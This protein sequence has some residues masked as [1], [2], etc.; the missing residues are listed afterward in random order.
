MEKFEKGQLIINVFGTTGL[1]ADKGK[2]GNFYATLQIKDIKKNEVIH[3]L[4]TKVIKN[5]LNPEWNESFVLDIRCEESF[6]LLMALEIT[7]KSMGKSQFMGKLDIPLQPLLEDDC[8]EGFTLQKRTTEDVVEGELLLGLSYASE[9]KPR[10]IKI[11][12]VSTMEDLENDF[13]NNEDDFEK[14]PYYF[15]LEDTEDNIHFEDKDKKILSGANIYKLIE[16]MTDIHPDTDLIDTVLLTIQS[17]TTAPQFLQ[18]LLQRYRGPGE[19]VTVEKCQREDFEK[20]ERNIHVRVAYIVERWFLLTDD[21]FKNDMFLLITDYNS[22]GCWGQKGALKEFMEDIAQMYS[23]ERKKSNVVDIDK[24]STFKTITSF[25]LIVEFSTSA[26]AEQMTLIEHE[27]YSK[28]KPWEFLKQSWTKKPESCPAAMGVINWF[29]KMSQWAAT[30]I[31]KGEDPERRGIIISKFIEICVRCA[32]LRNFGGVMEIL[33][34]LHNSAISRLKRSWACVSKENKE[35]FESLSKLMSPMPN[36][37]NYREEIAKNKSPWLPYLGIHLTDLTFIDD[38]NETYLD[39]ER[40]VI[41]VTK[42]KLLA[43][44][45]KT[46]RSG[47][48]LLYESISPSSTIQR[49]LK[50]VEIWEDHEIYRI[51]KLKEESLKK[52]EELKEPTRGSLASAA[53]TMM[54]KKAVSEVAKELSE[55]DWR[56]ITA[57]AAE[58]NFPK[59]KVIIFE[60]KTNENLY[61]IKEGKARVERGD[62]ENPMVVANLSEGSVFGEMSVILPS[63]TA[64]ATVISEGAVVWV[65]PIGLIYSIFEHHQNLAS[66]FYLNMAHKLAGVL[67]NLNPKSAKSKEESVEN[68]QKEAGKILLDQGVE[69]SSH[70]DQF[71]KLFS[72][73]EEEIIMKQCDCIYKKKKGTL[74]ITN[75]KI[76]FHAEVFMVTTKKTIQIASITNIEVLKTNIE[77]KTK[78]DS[79]LFN[80]LQTSI[81]NDVKQFVS[82]INNKLLIS[83]NSSD[84]GDKEDI[85]SLQNNWIENVSITNSGINEITIKVGLKK[86][87]FTCNTS[88]KNLELSPLCGVWKKQEGIVDEEKQESMDAIKTQTMTLEDWDKLLGGAR[89]QTF[90]KGQEIIIA[91]EPFQSL[92]QIEKGACDVIIPVGEGKTITVTQLN[93]GEIFGEISFIMNSENKRYSP[94]ASVVAAHDDVQVAVIS[95]YFVSTLFDLEVGFAGRFYKYLAQILAKRVQNQIIFF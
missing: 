64:S 44:S 8:N 60:S 84:L 68:T 94:G 35:R 79:H 9:T 91:G 15:G 75:V 7:K 59:E 81:T 72:F 45:I 31:I 5:V 65:I 19:L 10:K 33:S 70:K 95:G 54:K 50:S 43:T 38:G 3:N 52:G 83:N 93:E 4:K 89:K 20:N 67:T 37:K 78:S 87:V 1:L 22:R 88:L 13:D 82:N 57:G 53:K 62:R 42:A 11:K 61:K 18:L 27:N 90:K 30:E 32:E 49:V 17:F 55:K 16:K 63:H 80:L 24:K 47:S 29:N 92:Y 14:L 77:F 74:I 2:K 56:L 23:F 86:F 34:A 26:I 40:T 25:P 46:I 71:A 73:D 36:F 28:V 76:H 48:S 12:Q 41:N 85:Q 58:I 6:P 69:K 66:R 21:F 51:S 39:Q